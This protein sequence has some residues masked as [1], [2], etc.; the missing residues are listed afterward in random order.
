[1]LEDPTIL[2]VTTGD[3]APG[4]SPHKISAKPGKD[5]ATVTFTLGPGLHVPLA[6]WAI[7]LGGTSPVSGERIAH[8]GAI[9]GLAVCGADVPAAIPPDTE[10]AKA[11]NYSDID[12]GADGQRDLHIYSWVD[13]NDAV[14]LG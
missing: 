6:A 4:D 2:S 5:V 13:P 11:I 7:H 12:G 3:A 10:V 1:M 14:I 9:C 8:L